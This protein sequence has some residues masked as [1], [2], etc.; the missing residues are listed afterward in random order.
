[1]EHQ[2]YT[3]QTRNRTVSMIGVVGLEPENDGVRDAETGI[4]AGKQDIVVYSVECSTE[5]EGNN[6]E[7]YW[8]EKN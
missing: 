7:K 3:R 1:V 8:C 4:E 2:R 5:I 6:N